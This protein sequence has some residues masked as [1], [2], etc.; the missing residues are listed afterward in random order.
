[1]QSYDLPA[2]VPV[3]FGLGR[4]SDL[5]KLAAERLGPEQRVLL[6]AD[7]FAVSSGLAGRLTQGLAAAGHTSA[8]FSDLASDPREG[9]VDACARAARDFGASAVIALGG[10]SAMDVGKLAAAIVGVEEGAA[11]YALTIKPFPGN[12]LP[13]VAI[14]Q[15]PKTMPPKNMAPTASNQRRPTRWNDGAF[16]RTKNR[17]A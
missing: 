10:G 14:D 2:A 15:S 11:A 6:V 13:V 5:G 3:A 1:M 7:P 9:H 16:S 4:L 17:P 12:G 8:L